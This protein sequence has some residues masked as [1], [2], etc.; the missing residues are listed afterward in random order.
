MPI[1][2]DVVRIANFESYLVGEG[3]FQELIQAVEKVEAAG[4]FEA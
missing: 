1:L 4:Y 2:I 3:Y